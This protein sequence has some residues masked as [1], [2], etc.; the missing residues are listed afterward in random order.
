MSARLPLRA[1]ARTR[2]AVPPVSRPSLAAAVRFASSSEASSSKTP[3]TPAAAD[4]K[5][6]AKDVKNEAN[7]GTIYPVPPLARPLGV[8]AAPTSE[9]KSAEQKRKELLDAER[10]K[11]KRRALCVHRSGCACGLGY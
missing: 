9:P 3:A 8:Y 10:H 6:K 1:L 11:A 5:G 4:V 7:N 2:V